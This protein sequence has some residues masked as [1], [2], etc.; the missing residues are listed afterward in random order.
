MIFSIL[1]PVPFVADITAV[2]IVVSIRQTAIRTLG[3]NFDAIVPCILVHIQPHSL[4]TLRCG[5]RVAEVLAVVATAHTGP[6]DRITAIYTVLVLVEVP[7]PV[8]CLGLELL[9]DAVER[10]GD[11]PKGDDEPTFVQEEV[12]IASV[13]FPYGIGIPD[14]GEHGIVGDFSTVD[15]PVLGTAEFI[16]IGVI[17]EAITGSV[18]ETYRTDLFPVFHV[19]PPV[20]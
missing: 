7:A 16:D 15:E 17:E 5:L 13:Y 10:F 3:A 19:E 4:P 14:A 9:F 12:A 18:L 20:D 2:H 6:W 8:E 11:F 1:F